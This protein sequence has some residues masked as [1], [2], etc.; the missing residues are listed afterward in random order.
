MC[1]FGVAVAAEGSL[2]CVWVGLYWM[3]FPCVVGLAL[4]GWGCW[5]CAVGLSW[6]GV[7]WAWLLWAGLTSGLG[8][9]AWGSLVLLGW[10]GLA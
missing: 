7:G 4:V 10:L 3:G 5:A 6:G 8:C 9:A 2:S 1:K